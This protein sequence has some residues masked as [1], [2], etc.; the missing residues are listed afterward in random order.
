[1][2]KVLEEIS[3]D[4]A[5]SERGGDWPVEFEMGTKFE[6][7]EYRDWVYVATPGWSCKLSGSW[8]SREEESP[9]PGEKDIREEGEERISCN[10]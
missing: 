10:S 6:S 1:M 7:P 5:E 8:I 2:A 9:N 4:E 3:K